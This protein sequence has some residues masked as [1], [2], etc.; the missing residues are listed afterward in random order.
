MAQTVRH[1][2]SVL[3]HINGVAFFFLVKAS[4]LSVE[5]EDICFKRSFVTSMELE[6]VSFNLLLI[7]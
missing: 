1:L 5:M 7:L 3:S 2:L 6:I 4:N